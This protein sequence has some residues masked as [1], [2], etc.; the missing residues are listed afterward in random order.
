MSRSLRFLLSVVLAGALP[1][2]V[3]AID[4]HERPNVLLILADD[5]FW[6][7]LEF[8]QF[9]EKLALLTRCGHALCTANRGHPGP[10]T[11]Y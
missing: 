9:A 5:E 7:L 2:A 6:R 8:R 11:S 10:I 4:A 3:R 1:T